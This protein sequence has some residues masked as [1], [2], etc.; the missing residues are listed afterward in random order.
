MGT[1]V[2]A[3]SR[4]NQLSFQYPDAA[5]DLQAWYDLIRKSDFDNFAQLRRVVNSVSLVNGQ[6]VFNI[7]GNR[8]RLIVTVFWGGK[9]L[10]VKSL[11]THKAYDAWSAEQRRRT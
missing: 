1:R 3:K 11:L 2:I 5:Q 6:L 8:Y 9:Q 4:L 7:R 10:Y